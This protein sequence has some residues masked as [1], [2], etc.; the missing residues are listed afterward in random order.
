MLVVSVNNSRETPSRPAFRQQM[1]HHTA[2]RG[3]VPLLFK[4]RMLQFAAKLE[5]QRGW[6]PARG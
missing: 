4:E 6:L 5:L 1:E 2:S 3:Q